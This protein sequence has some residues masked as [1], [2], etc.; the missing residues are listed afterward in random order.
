MRVGAA[1]VLAHT[2]SLNKAA[3]FLAWS[4]FEVP[5]GYAS[6]DEEDELWGDTEAQLRLWVEREQTA[7]RKTLDTPAFRVTTKMTRT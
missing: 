7:I 6:E 3:S 2:G 4:G 1:S 5:P